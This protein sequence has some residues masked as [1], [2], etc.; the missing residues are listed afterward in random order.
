M[1]SRCFSRQQLASSFSN[2]ANAMRL[3]ILTRGVTVTAS[4]RSASSGPASAA[5]SHLRMGRLNHSYKS[6][7]QSPSPTGNHPYVHDHFSRVVHNC[8]VLHCTTLRRLTDCLKL[9]SDCR[10]LAIMGPSGS[11]KTTLLNTLA[12]QVA[13]Q[14]KLDLTGEI[15]INGQP[16]ETANVRQGYVQQEDMFFSQLTV[17]YAGCHA[18][19]LLSA[20]QSS[21][22]LSLQHARSD[23]SGS[24][25]PCSATSAVLQ[26]A[27]PCA[28]ATPAW[29]KTMA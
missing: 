26:S 25:L 8:S 16:I 22:P 20:M 28:Q 9:L 10:L 17:R 19:H 24:H 3:A 2:L 12:R 21:A 1:V 6:K 13:C 5:A 4:S 11:G 27:F 14:K 23:A 15:L 29:Y 18:L 7:A